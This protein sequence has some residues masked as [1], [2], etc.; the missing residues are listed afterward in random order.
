MTTEGYKRGICNRCG[1]ELENPQKFLCEEC[2]K[3]NRQETREKELQKQRDRVAKGLCRFCEKTALEGKTL[4]AYHQ[5]KEYERCIRKYPIEQSKDYRK[6]HGLCLVC[7]RPVESEDYY[8]CDSCRKKASD[9]LKIKRPILVTYEQIKIKKKSL[10]YDRKEKGLCVYCGKPATHGLYCLDHYIKEQKRYQK[11]KE[12]TALKIAER[13][14]NH[15]CKKCGG[16]IEEGSDKKWCKKCRDEW[17]EVVRERHRQGIYKNS[18]HVWHGYD[19]LIY[20]HSTKK[21]EV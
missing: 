2:K 7:G 20:Q 1:K 13:E 17:A 10:Y 19:T 6:E 11:R 5:Q 3:I 8:W 9:E 21:E 16:K 18:R 14:E 15:I 12:K 4:C